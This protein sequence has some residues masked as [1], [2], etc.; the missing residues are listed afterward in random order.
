[1]KVNVPLDHGFLPD[2]YAKKAA[3]E[4]QLKDHPIVSFPIDI[5]DAPAGTQT[6]ALTLVDF[7]AIPVCGFAWIHWTAANIPVELNHLPENASR[8]LHDFIQGNN[9]AAG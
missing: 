5:Q 3:P 9:S 4:F 1:M 7:D 8:E 6:F 2:K